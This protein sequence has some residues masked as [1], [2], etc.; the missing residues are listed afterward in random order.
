MSYAT[1]ARPYAK[2]AFERAV[3]SDH[4][5]AWS[6]ALLALS[7]AVSNVGVQ[8]Y[9]INPTIPTVEKIQLLERLCHEWLANDEIKCFLQLLGKNERLLVL[10]SISQGFEH[11]VEELNNRVNTLITTAYELSEVEKNHL[12]KALSEK[13][14][15]TLDVK[16]K[17]DKSIIGGVVIE[18]DGN[19]INASVQQ[20]LKQMKENLI[21]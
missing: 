12:I 14:K 19:V 2:A 5:Q 21:L 8:D 9:I 3:G 6:N 16:F 18:F 7:E 11:H 20:Q 15:H 13:L 17:I 1:Q 10:N 4:I